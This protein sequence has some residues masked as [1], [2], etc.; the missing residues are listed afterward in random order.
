MPDNDEVERMN[1]TIKETTVKR[2]HSDC[3]AQPWTHLELFLGP[4]NHARRRKTLRG[5]TP[6]ELVC[7][8]WTEEPNRFRLDPSHHIAGLYT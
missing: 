1:R 4:Y 2:F 8:T 5:F 3:H 6:Y 7:Q